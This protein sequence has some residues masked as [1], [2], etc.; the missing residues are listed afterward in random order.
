MSPQGMAD[1]AYKTVPVYWDSVR[2]ALAEFP[3]MRSD[4]LALPAS[5]LG[6]GLKLALPVMHVVSKL[7]CPVFLARDLSGLS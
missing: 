2:R 5:R 7:K 6:G 3:G 4:Q 1:P